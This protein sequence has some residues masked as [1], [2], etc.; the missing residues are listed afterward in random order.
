MLIPKGGKSHRVTVWYLYAM[1]LKMQS[2]HLKFK[3]KN[4]C[5]NSHEQVKMVQSNKND[6]FPSQAVL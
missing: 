3:V 5:L 1:R 4:K 6:S 2:G